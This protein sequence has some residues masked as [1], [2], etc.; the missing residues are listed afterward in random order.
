MLGLTVDAA[1]RFECFGDL[2]GDDL[3]EADADQ[4]FRDILWRSLL[5]DNWFA[6]GYKRK[7]L[8]LKSSC[9]ND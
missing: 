2:S 5:I 3:R 7:R 8:G 6:G 4:M 1:S 9:N